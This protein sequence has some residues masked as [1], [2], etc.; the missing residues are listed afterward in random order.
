MWVEFTQLKIVYNTLSQKWTIDDMITKF[1][2]EEEKLK[3]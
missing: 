3:K 2:V 1:V